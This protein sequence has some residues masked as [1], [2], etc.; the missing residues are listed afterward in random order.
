[1]TRPLLFRYIYTNK[2]TEKSDVYSFGVVLFELITGQPAIST[3][4]EGQRFSLVQHVVSELR[5]GD[6]N[7][8]I[9][10]RLHGQYDISSVWKVAETA[11][12]CTSEKSVGRPTM[13]SVVSQLKEATEIEMSNDGSGS[14]TMPATTADSLSAGKTI[15]SATGLSDTD[16]EI[17]PSAR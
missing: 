17:Y 3:D 4:V 6:I 14:W 5:R 2:L 1:M 12:T 10:P 7:S 13:T 11:M 8:I 9:D 15:L 16:L